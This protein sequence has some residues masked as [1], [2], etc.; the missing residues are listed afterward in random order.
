MRL[1]QTQ[2]T[3]METPLRSKRPK[4]RLI[5]HTLARIAPGVVTNDLDTTKSTAS[6]GPDEDARTHWHLH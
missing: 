3:E 2:L 1:L 6:I 4:G 5:S